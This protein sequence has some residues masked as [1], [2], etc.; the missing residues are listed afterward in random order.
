LFL[1]LVALG[2]PVLE[3]V[4][5]FARRILSG[6]PGMKADRRHLFHYLSM[7][8]LPPR[9]IVL[10]FNVLGIV[11]GMI[12]LSMYLWQRALVLA[13][14]LVFMVVILVLFYI[15]VSGLPARVRQRR[16]SVGD[17][18]RAGDGE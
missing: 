6:K 16:R 11:F 8:G 13:L 5:S 15:L 3:T 1:P 7:A 18:D 17:E 9:R 2:V 12:A 4:T 10:V 14:L